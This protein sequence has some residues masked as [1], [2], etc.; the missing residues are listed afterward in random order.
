MQIE[1]TTT[2]HIKSQRPKIDES[3]VN[4]EIKAASVTLL[5]LK[6]TW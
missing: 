3:I 6:N 2:I 1:N 4:K 5:D